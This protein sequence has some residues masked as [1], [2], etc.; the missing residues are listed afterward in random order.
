LNIKACQPPTPQDRA[1][2]GQDGHQARVKG[3]GA[4]AEPKKR[5]GLANLN[6]LINILAGTPALTSITSNFTFPNRRFN[7]KA[8]ASPHTTRSSGARSGRAP[9]QS[10]GEKGA[11]EKLNKECG[12]V[13]V[14]NI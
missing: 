4:A 1:K 12:A 6:H 5:G 7:R 8:P 14:K 2:S 9:G 13:S 10:E 11:A 3:R